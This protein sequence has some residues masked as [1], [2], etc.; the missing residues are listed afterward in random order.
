MKPW[1][2]RGAGKA[3]WVWT[4]GVLTCVGCVIFAG[5]CTPNW[6]VWVF[7]EAGVKIR[8]FGVVGAMVTVDPVL[9]VDT[10]PGGVGRRQ[11]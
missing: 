8:R 2:L 9:V 6:L 1:G 10:A 4:W 11:N 5:S 7:V 3:T